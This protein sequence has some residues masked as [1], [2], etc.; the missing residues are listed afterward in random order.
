MRSGGGRGWGA[1][2][3][4]DPPNIRLSAL[5]VP[6][7]DQLEALDQVGGSASI[8]A[9]QV[10]TPRYLT[11]KDGPRMPRKSCQPEGGGLVVDSLLRGARF[12]AVDEEV[13]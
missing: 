1:A 4:L 11:L 8:I 12:G 5:L 9:T 13:K 6:G 2:W 3:A 10:L 7:D